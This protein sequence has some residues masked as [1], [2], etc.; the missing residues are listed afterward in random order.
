SIEDLL[1]GSLPASAKQHRAWWSND[2]HHVQACSW[3]E[4]GWRVA[5]VNMT[6]G[7]VTFAKTAG[8]ERDY[9][10]FFAELLDQ[11]ADLKQHGA[12]LLDASPDGSS[13]ITLARLPRRDSSIAM[14][15]FSFTHRR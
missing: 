7:V 4:A 12:P 9:I 5:T 11:L 6:E 14:V 13:W 3:L 2:P 10:S 1:G 15:N 8:I